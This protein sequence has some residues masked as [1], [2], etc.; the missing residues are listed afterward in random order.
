MPWMDEGN[1]TTLL[2][3]RQIHSRHQPLRSSRNR[4]QIKATS[5]DARMIQF[6]IDPAGKEWV[7][8]NH[9][10]RP[11]TMGSESGVAE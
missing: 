8:T 3:A 9:H 4:N 7:T 6:D 5:S 2:T 10:R 11:C 1:P